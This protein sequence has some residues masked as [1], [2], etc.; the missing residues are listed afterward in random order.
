MFP[1]FQL[2]E[3]DNPV[4]MCSHHYVVCL[5]RKNQCFEVLDS[6]RSGDDTSLTTHAEFFIHDL[7]ETWNHHYGSSKVKISH[8]PIE[9]ITTAKHDC[10]FY[11]L[12][13]LAKWEGRRVPVITDAIV[14]ELRKIFTW[15]WV[16]NED[17]NKWASTRDFIEGAVKTANKKYK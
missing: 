12:E 1:M 2:L 14:V 3:P 5:D 15:N 8:F 6:I 9:Y 7:K 10:S 4:D 11:M 13:Y 17:F 16:M